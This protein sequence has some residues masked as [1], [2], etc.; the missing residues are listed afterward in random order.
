MKNKIMISLL[1]SSV[2]SNGRSDFLLFM[3]EYW[4]R[5]PFDP[6]LKGVLR[7]S[8]FFIDSYLLR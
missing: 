8:K 3:I 6:S 4:I 5:C 7:D 2:L 1:L